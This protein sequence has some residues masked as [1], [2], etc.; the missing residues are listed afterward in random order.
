MSQLSQRA[1]MVAKNTIGT[2][3]AHDPN[4][5]AIREFIVRIKVVMDK[6]R[7]LNRPAINVAAFF[8]IRH[9]L[10]ELEK[11]LKGI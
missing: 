9:E 11:R 5:P 7:E 10:D 4:H 3:M 1:N 2:L 6:A 8:I